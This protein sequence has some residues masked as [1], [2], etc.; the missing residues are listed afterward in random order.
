[1]YRNG[2]SLT[3]RVFSRPVHTTIGVVG[4]SRSFVW[5]S[6]LLVPSVVGI[7][8]DGWCLHV[9]GWSSRDVTSSASWQSHSLRGAHRSLSPEMCD[10]RVTGLRVPYGRQAQLTIPQPRCA[11]ADK[12]APVTWPFFKP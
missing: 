11:R 12:L 10:V 9:T 3:V 7:R 4:I 2:I 5:L 8:A 6:V 1:M